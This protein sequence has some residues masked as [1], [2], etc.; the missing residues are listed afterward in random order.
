MHLLGDELFAC[1]VVPGPGPRRIVLLMTGCNTL[2]E[3]DDFLKSNIAESCLCS[4]SENRYEF[5]LATFL[6]ASLVEPFGVFGGM[7]QESN[8]LD[9]STSFSFVLRDHAET[10]H[11]CLNQA[12][13]AVGQQSLHTLKLP[14]ARTP[15]VLVDEVQS[16]S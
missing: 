16:S 5:G 3:F 12:D 15:R 11:A 1:D 9:H 2:R 10:A 4:S 13:V 7:R 6:V 14:R 8:R